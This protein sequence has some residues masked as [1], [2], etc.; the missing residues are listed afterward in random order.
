MNHIRA[1]GNDVVEA[2]QSKIVQIPERLQ[3]TR[4]SRYQWRHSCVDRAQ[5][6]KPARQAPDSN[7]EGSGRCDGKE[8]ARKAP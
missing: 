6:G 1:E 7:D 4:D 8:R 5:G 2:L 3:P